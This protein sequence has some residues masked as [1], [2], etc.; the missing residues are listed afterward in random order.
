MGDHLLLSEGVD[1]VSLLG[2]KSMGN[3]ASD[4]IDAYALSRMGLE[5]L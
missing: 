2:M 3:P 5:D 4:I 1:V